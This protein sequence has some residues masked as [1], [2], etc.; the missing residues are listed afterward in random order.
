MEAIV[1]DTSAGIAVSPGEL[2][3]T[4]Q[5]AKLTDEYTQRGLQAA[6]KR[7]DLRAVRI[8]NR[9]YTTLRDINN[10]LELM[11]EKGRSKYDPWATGKR[12]K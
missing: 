8:G 2:L 3:T 10:F 5:A 9:D 1:T 12:T 11:K 6:I 7:G 4:G